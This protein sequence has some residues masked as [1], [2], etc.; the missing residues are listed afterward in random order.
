MYNHCKDKNINNNIINTYNND[1]V[2]FNIETIITCDDNPTSLD[3]DKN[4]QEFIEKV[5]NVL[6]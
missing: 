1:T 5:K 6:K 4:K 3:K 2:K